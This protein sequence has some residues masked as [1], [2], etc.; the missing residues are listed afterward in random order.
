[1]C[2]LCSYYDSYTRGM[3]LMARGDSDGA[4][5]GARSLRNYPASGI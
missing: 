5:M 4:D 3:T 1:M 2:C